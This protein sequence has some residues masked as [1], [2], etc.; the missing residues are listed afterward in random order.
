[1]V[2]Y[3]AYELVPSGTFLL[4]LALENCNVLP[5]N[6]VLY[7][8]SEKWKRHSI[9]DSIPEKV[10]RADLTTLVANRLGEKNNDK[11]SGTGTCTA[12]GING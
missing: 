11:N 12:T 5:L 4:L 3:G 1:M 6:L 8:L 9:I 10:S 2:S 7:I